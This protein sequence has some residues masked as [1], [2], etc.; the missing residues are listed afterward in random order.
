MRGR[1]ETGGQ[2][3]AAGTRGRDG[4]S[5]KKG[6]QVNDMEAIAEPIESPGLAATGHLAISIPRSLPTHADESINRLL[7]GRYKPKCV[8][9]RRADGVTGKESA[10]IYEFEGVA[11]VGDIGLEA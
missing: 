11:Q 9:A 6:Q 5:R 10:E 3:Q 7:E 4:I 1:S 8:L 2:A